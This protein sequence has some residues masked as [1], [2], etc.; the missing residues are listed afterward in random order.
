MFNLF[1]RDLDR[2]KLWTEKENI[3]PGGESNPG[4]PRDR[5]GYS[6]L[7]YRG[8]DENRNILNKNQQCFIKLLK[9][10]VQQYTYL[11]R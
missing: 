11:T 1:R 6:P 4:L 3:L 8:F 9:V 10:S 2:R 5:R 7:Y